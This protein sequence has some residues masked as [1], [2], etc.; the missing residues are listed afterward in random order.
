L[1]KETKIPT[2]WNQEGDNDIRMTRS[3]LNNERKKSVLPHSS[4]DLDGDGVVGNRDLVIAKRFD[5]DGDGILNEQE[6]REALE[7]ISKVLFNM[8]NRDMK[9]ILLGTLRNQ[10]HIDHTE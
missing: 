8:T 4:Y 3:L 9:I 1:K 2:W 6:K 5:K 7:A 10:E